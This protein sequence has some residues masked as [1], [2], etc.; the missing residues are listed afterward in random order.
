MDGV[1]WY[2]GCDRP[3]CRGAALE[4]QPNRERNFLAVMG[5]IPK[6]RL[7]MG[8]MLGIIASWFYT[9]GSWQIYVIKTQ[10]P[11]LSRGSSP[12]SG[13]GSFDSC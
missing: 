11:C 9:L 4:V 8:D 7:F 3:T 6:E 1:G 12:A 5:S 2:C 10:L 13:R